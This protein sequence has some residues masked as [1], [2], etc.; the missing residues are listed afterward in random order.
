[1][2]DEIKIIYKGVPI[3]TEVYNEMKQGI[4]NWGIAN[5]KK[6]DKANYD[7]GISDMETEIN[8]GG[9]DVPD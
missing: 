2:N 5:I 3:P 8:S 4:V 9:F 6:K 1:M 7:L